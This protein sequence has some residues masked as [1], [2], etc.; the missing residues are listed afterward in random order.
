VASMR[1][2]PLEQQ[3]TLAEA[4][5]AQALKAVCAWLIIALMRAEQV[6]AGLLREQRLSHLLRQRALAHLLQHHAQG[7]ADAGRHEEDAVA[8][9]L[10]PLA[11][12][13][14]GDVP[15]PPRA[16]D[17]A[18]SQME[19]YAGLLRGDAAGEALMR[20]LHD[21]VLRA[22]A[23]GERLA[24]EVNHEQEEEAEEEA[25]EEEEKEQQQEQ[26]QEQEKEVM[27][28]EPAPKGFA[29]EDEGMAAWALHC[30]R[31]PPSAD[32]SASNLINAALARGAAPF[33]P[34]DRFTVYRFGGKT[35]PLK[36]PARLWMSSNHF[37]SAWSF[38]SHRR[39]KNIICA[40]E[41][42]PP[43][44]RPS[45]LDRGGGGSASSAVPIETER[46]QHAFQYFD[47][48]SDGMVTAAELAA[49]GRAVDLE[50]VADTA[51]AVEDPT[52][53]ALPLAAI[54]ASVG[55]Q[56]RSS[57]DGPGERFWVVLSLQEAEALRGALHI[58]RAHGGKLWADEEGGEQPL[59]AL[60][61]DG[62][63]LDAVRRQQ[64]S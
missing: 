28:Q 22:G 47:E 43:G 46:V 56:V 34:L 45:N 52:V 21:D 1:G 4:T 8:V 38:K 51:A 42:R 9:F 5:Q 17:R 60:H 7:G 40:M 57:Q 39:L 15:V 33:Y 31:E 3:K 55:E 41:W 62:A 10:E 24:L 20:R 61:S 37:R 29:R 63:L 27:S 12:D 16:G 49:L 26:E 48:N 36:W 30:L 11:H 23:S 19:R 6:Q 59:V 18:I 53:P 58:S 25:E 35:R 13:I 50:S 54:D 2:V 64:T 14:P 32:Q 44:F